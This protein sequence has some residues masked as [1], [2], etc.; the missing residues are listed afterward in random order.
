MHTQKTHTHTGAEL[1]PNGQCTCSRGY[2]LS[3]NKLQC[4]QCPAF[5]YS[6]LSATNI[7][8][9]ICEYPYT[10]PAGGKCTY[11]NPVWRPWTSAKAT[12]ASDSASVG[13][14][15]TPSAPGLRSSPQI[16]A[17]GGMLYVFGGY[18]SN[19]TIAINT[20]LNSNSAGRVLANLS[21]I[22]TTVN[23]SVWEY[24]QGLEI[25]AP[26]RRYMHTMVEL[27]GL[28]FVY[29]GL[30]EGGVTHSDMYMYNA[31]SVTLAGSET[32]DGMWSP[33]DVA[34]NNMVG[35]APSGRS[36]HA[37][38]A[39]PKRNKFGDL[40]GGSIFIFGGR[41]STGVLISDLYEFRYYNSTYSTWLNRTGLPNQPSAR[42][43]F[44]M[45]H[46]LGT[47]YVFWGRTVA[48][49]SNVYTLDVRSNTPVWGTL[50]TLANSPIRRYAHAAFSIETRIYI[51]GGRLSTTNAVVNEVW[52]LEARNLTTPVPLLNV[53]WRSLTTL[54]N[55]PS[56]RWFPGFT[57]LTP[58]LK[59]VFVFGGQNSTNGVLEDLHELDTKAVLCK[60]GYHRVNRV[61]VA[62]SVGVYKAVIEELE[63]TVCFFIICVCFVASCRG[64]G[65]RGMFF[66]VRGFC[67]CVCIHVH[68]CVCVCEECKA[69]V[70]VLCVCIY[71][72]VC[73]CMYVCV[74]VCEE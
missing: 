19:V 23:T 35:V 72:H 65:V 8:D 21:R 22:N 70:K 66:V 62:C 17:I 48:A 52:Q 27:G 15:R 29:G 12:T 59:S 28:L 55:T 37:A 67:V 63:C 14:K 56:A 68:V 38:V 16:A 25:S 41:S 51:I 53:S 54:P 69:V 43:Q 45:A 57:A 49:D 4:L 1:L 10:G 7:T 5:S 9:C 73:M 31:S 42:D 32:I 3:P 18:S 6:K 40:Q 34:S 39:V 20:N 30:G 46:V 50:A 74:C 60:P 71:V 58:V 13:W 64:A 24:A 47:V 11:D 2:Y 61:C 26:P 44:A 33:V 36:G